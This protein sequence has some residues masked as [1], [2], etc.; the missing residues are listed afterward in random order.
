MVD[1]IILA[2]DTCPVALHGKPPIEVYNVGRSKPIPFV[3]FIQSIV[4][5]M[6]CEVELRLLDD[7]P[8]QFGEPIEI[9]ADTSKL[10]NDLAYSPVWDHEEGVPHFIKWY[11]EYYDNS[12]G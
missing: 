5:A 2:L 1:G 12:A 8:L 10:E 9:Y 4:A 11:K 7:S 3:A 6:G